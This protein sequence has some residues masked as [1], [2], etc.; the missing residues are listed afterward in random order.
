MKKYKVIVFINSC[1]ENVIYKNL[2][3]TLLSIHNNINTDYRFYISTDKEEHKK[4][5]LDI[6]K[7]F[8]F[9]D[10]FLEIEINNNSWSINFNEFFSKYSEECEYVLASHDDIKVRT[11]DFFN[12]TMNEISG[13]EDEIGWIGYTSDNH[14]TKLNAIVCQSAREIFSKDRK[15]WPK[16]FELH[17]MGNHF[18]ENLLDYPKRACKVPG[19][20]SHFNLIKC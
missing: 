15:Q 11:F 19:I 6:S 9:T 4:E 17:K 18:D 1:G 7:K 8:N 12:I 13:F 3:D 20:Y 2:E 10:N 5:I 16:V 14:Y